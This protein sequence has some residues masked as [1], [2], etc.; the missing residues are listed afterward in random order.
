[1]FSH[2]ARRSA[3]G[4]VALA[5]A[6][7]T[8]A[9][10]ASPAAAA[11]PRTIRNSS[12]AVLEAGVGS[13]APVSF[14]FFNGTSS[15]QWEQ[16][17]SPTGPVYRVWFNRGAKRCLDV[18]R[19]L[20]RAGARIVTRPCDGTLS[21]DWHRQIAVGGKR[22]FINRFSGLVM[23]EAGDIIQLPSGAGGN[24]KFALGSTNP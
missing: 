7:T 17:S 24:Q 18:E 23:T 3:L 16:R 8:I 9:V 20:R 12:N 6:T 10:T 21:Q 4:V 19:D 5:V 2:Q 15:E 1:M 14:G 22:A 13:G 11:T